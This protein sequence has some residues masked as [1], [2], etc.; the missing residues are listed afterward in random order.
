MPDPSAP[1]VALWRVD[2]QTVRVTQTT[3]IGPNHT[4]VP[5]LELSAGAGSLWVTDYDSGT[6]VRVNPESGQVI[7]TIRI[8]GHPFGIAFGA[9]RIWVTVS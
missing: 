8:G 9:N 5:T 6:V 3:T 7:S 2:P 1:R 4:Y